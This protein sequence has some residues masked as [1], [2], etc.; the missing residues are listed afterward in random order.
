MPR[1]P[2]RWTPEEDRVLLDKVK[3]LF[4]DGAKNDTTISWATV[5]NALPDRNNK[6]CRKRWSKITGAKKGSWSLSEDEQLLEGVQKYGR[7]WA[8]VAKG[9]ETRSADQCAK[10]WQHCLDPSLDRS[11]WTS[12][13]DARLVA[14]VR[15]YGTNW[16]DIKKFEFPK[17]STTNLKNRHIALFRQRNKAP[18]ACPGA[19][20]ALGP[21][22]D[23][24][25][26]EQEMLDDMSIDASEDGDDT[27]DNQSPD[28]YTSISTCSFDD[29]LGGSPSGPSAADTMN[30]VSSDPYQYLLDWTVP[31]HA[32]LVQAATSYYPALDGFLGSTYDRNANIDPSLGRSTNGGNFIPGFPTQTPSQFESIDVSQISDGVTLGE[33]VP[34]GVNREHRAASNVS[35]GPQMTVTIDNPDPQTMTGILEVLAKANNNLCFR[36]F[37]MQCLSLKGSE[38][39]N[40]NL[41]DLRNVTLL[42]YLTSLEIGTGHT[43]KSENV[44]PGSRFHLPRFLAPITDESCSGDLSNDKQLNR[45][46]CLHRARLL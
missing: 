10:R 21:G 40:N 25:S 20:E 14:A 16:K 36:H 19:M 41:A 13:Q 27:E 18:S 7:Q 2:R 46:D 11:E 42:L 35:S 15:R 43:N 4:S 17:R 26:I 30:T 23:W 9:V 31:S 8:M 28:S 24:W 44:T 3:Q 32:D 34:Q 33:S 1:S 12:D 6:D 5:A 45:P 38:K 22:I 29:I 37:V 39:I